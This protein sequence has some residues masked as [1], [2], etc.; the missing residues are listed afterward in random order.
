MRR[1]LVV[2]VLLLAGCGGGDDASEP[3]TLSRTELL[4][5]ET[6]KEC[7]SDHFREWS[8]SMHAYAADD[9][10]FVAM[11]RRG[12]EETN[13]A[14]GDFC[15]RC[16]APMA[17]SEG[18]TKDGLNLDQLPQHL[19]GVTCYFC[20]DA[21]SVSGTHNNPIELSG[22]VTMRG[23]IS[24][25]VS[26]SAHRS[27]YSSLL[28]RKQLDSAKLCGTCHDIVLPSP[29]APAEVHLERTFEEWQGTL[30][31]KEPSQ[32]GLT[33]GG[34]HMAGRD[35]VA[36]DAPGVSVRRLHS[37]AFP[38]VDVALDPLPEADAQKA[39]IQSLLDTTLRLQIC[40]QQLPG[41]A[42]VE[43]LLENVSA[44]HRWPS[45]AAQDRRA[46]VELRA[47]EQGAAVYE[48]GVVA[49][50]QPVTELSDPDLWLLRDRTKKS[51][52]TDAHMFWE[53]ASY[54]SD[55][56]PG[57]VTFDKSDPD[58]FITHVTRA[59]PSF[60][61]APDRVTARVRL[62]PVG[63]DVIGSLVASGHLDAGVVGKLPT[64]DM[65]PNRDQSDVTLEW[66]PEKTKDP[67]L[68]FTKLIDGVPADCVTG[69]AAVT[70]K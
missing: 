65:I 42:R 23:G 24:D 15:V 20:H 25:P 29:P 68:G 31:A 8:G 5:P 59:Y 6:C 60:A 66:T 14:L 22:G 21:K 19:K 33:C 2:G 56:I 49:D 4:N 45:G 58:Y 69:A 38:G 54:E 13:G 3:D 32:G 67:K 9:P 52:G 70:Q 47:F 28:D 10:V 12:Q 36:A 46:W 44:G 34:C 18:A 27:E 30:F 16:H 26:N 50:G 17:V 39:A 64:F 51:D 43:L 40:V 62:R 55:T 35:G 11:N 1:A 41:S 53:V 37:H 61:G 7:H 57:P 63:L 48:S